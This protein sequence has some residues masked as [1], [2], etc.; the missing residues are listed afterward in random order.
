MLRSA[1]QAIKQVTNT[2]PTKA[3]LST[4]RPLELLHMDLYGPTTYA[5]VGGNLYRL[6]VV[7][8]Y[9]RYISVVFLQDKTKVV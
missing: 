1:C 3:F 6:I 7:D 5:S 8:D 4:S 2:H 9:S